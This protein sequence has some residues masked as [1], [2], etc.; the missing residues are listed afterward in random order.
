MPALGLGDM[1]P[2]ADARSPLNEAALDDAR[3]DEDVG[4]AFINAIR[5][6]LQE[7]AAGAL[8]PACSTQT[9]GELD[10]AAQ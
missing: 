1:T 6:P 10:S 9:T 8:P 2:V 5:L 7:P 4:A 3:L